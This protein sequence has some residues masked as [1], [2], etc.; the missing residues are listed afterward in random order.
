MEFGLLLV[1]VQWTAIAFLSL[2]LFLALFE[3]PLAYRLGAP[4]SDGVASSS[5]S[6]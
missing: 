1:V 6:G 2:M 3:P 5:P 4:P